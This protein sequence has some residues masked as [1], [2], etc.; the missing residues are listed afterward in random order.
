MLSP[1]Q[2]LTL[3]QRATTSKFFGANSGTTQQLTRQWLLHQTAT[4]F[5]NSLIARDGRH[6]RAL[7]IATLNL[8]FFDRN[9]AV[10]HSIYLWHIKH[11]KWSP[12]WRPLIFTVSN[13]MSIPRC[14]N[15]IE[16]TLQEYGIQG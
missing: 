4:H 12:M 3:L 10:Y 2:E 1:I 14:N 6:F 5:K 11:G 8:P 9:T 15:V 7:F 16:T 13:S